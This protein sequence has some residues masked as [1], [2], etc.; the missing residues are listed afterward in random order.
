MNFLTYSIVVPCYNESKNIPIILEKFKAAIG[1]IPLEVVLVNNGSTDDSQ[2][3]LDKLLPDYPFAKTVP[4]KINKGYGY[5]IWTGL[6]ACTGAVLGWTHADLQTDPKDVILA[7][8]K[9]KTYGDPKRLF[10]KGLRKGRP[11]FDSFF[12]VG[13]SLFESLYLGSTLWDINAQPNMFHRYFFEILDTPPSDFSFDL[14]V[15]F[16]AKREGFHVH[17]FPVKFP[18][19]IH[20]HSSWNTGLLA[21]WKFIKRTLEFSVSL[22]KVL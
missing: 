20:G 5:G 12:T 21:K 9:F 17:R 11:L 10:V 19:R 22:K 6:N 4:V 16:K 3:V 1:D 7:I 14:Y 2:A 13:M 18:K 8:E 15:L